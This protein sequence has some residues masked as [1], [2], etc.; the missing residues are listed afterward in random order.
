M[1]NE[2]H[3]SKT[4]KF[5]FPGLLGKSWFQCLTGGIWIIILISLLFFDIEPFIFR[6]LLLPAIT[7]PALVFVACA[8]FFRTSIVAFWIGVL[9][10]ITIY[11]IGFKLNLQFYILR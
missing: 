8:M 4:P 9:V 3:I 11:L 2:K 7:L 1:E 6:L 5:P 10:G